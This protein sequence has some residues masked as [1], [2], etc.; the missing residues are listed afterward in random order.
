MVERYVSVDLMNELPKPLINFLWYLWYV[1]CDPY[2]D[3]SPF[4]LI[5]SSAK[6]QR[7]DIPYVNITVEQDFGTAIEAT[8]L[9][10]KEGAKYYMS[11]Q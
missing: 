10:Q 8:I 5:Q 6:G 9:I 1:Y 11:R 3:E 2:A 4:T 7:V